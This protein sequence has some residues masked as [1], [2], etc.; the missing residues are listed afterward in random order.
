[1]CWVNHVTCFGVY[2]LMLTHGLLKCQH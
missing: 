1:M 2:V